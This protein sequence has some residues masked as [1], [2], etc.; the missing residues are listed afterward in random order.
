MDEIDGD[1]PE[2]KVESTGVK[3]N[4][5]QSRVSLNSSYSSIGVIE[6][7]SS[8]K[9]I[10]YRSTGIGEEGGREEPEFRDQLKSIQEN[11]NKAKFSKIRRDDER[12]VNKRS[13]EGKSFLLTSS[14]PVKKL[15]SDSFGI[16]FPGPHSEEKE[17]GPVKKP[18]DKTKE[19]NE[20]KS[21][22]QKIKDTSSSKSLTDSKSSPM[23]S[24]NANPPTNKIRGYRDE[25][26]GI[27]LINKPLSKANIPISSI[28]T[29][30]IDRSSKGLVYNE[31][32]E[33]I[34]KRSKFYVSFLK[35]ITNSIDKN[36]FLTQSTLSSIQK[37]IPQNNNSIIKSITCRKCKN[38][39]IGITTECYH[40][41]CLSCYQISIQNL[42]YFKDFKSYSSCACSV[43]G[44]NGSFEFLS[45]LIPDKKIE[46]LSLCINR[47]CTWC[48][49]ELDLCKQHFPNETKCK[50]LC[51]LCYANEIFYNST[52]CF[53]CNLEYT[54]I[55]YTKKRFYN[56]SECKSA[57]Y[58]I[59][60]ILRFNTEGLC[61]CLMC[62]QKIL[63]TKNNNIFTEI[64]MK[65]LIN[66]INPTCPSCG[67]SHPV[68]N[69]VRY[70]D[71]SLINC[72]NCCMQSNSEFL[73]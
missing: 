14:Y 30:L 15:S 17:H 29:V 38:I 55:K 41:V 11:E 57:G 56:C 26:K 27:K 53:C 31:N 50:H 39:F 61:F 33:N 43:C 12:F 19:Q 69:I 1:L 67:I 42:L 34:E 70:P 60:D 45:N 10:R 21:I 5:L 73:C 6:K 28:I 52:S 54:N 9:Y 36:D 68:A 4:E 25:V 44:I 59:A 2:S 62:I 72:D 20:P 49:R 13:T 16:D 51:D 3:R 58:L 18:S 23:Y 35:L 65:V 66:L 63:Q 22:P 40:N 7:E 46:I 8:E 32:Q 24:E 37:N 47:I 48:H 64:E 71:C